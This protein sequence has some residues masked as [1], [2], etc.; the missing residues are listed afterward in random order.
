M[1]R[2]KN[3]F[4]GNRLVAVLTQPVQLFDQLVGAHCQEGL[5][6]HI[7]LYCVIGQRQIVVVRP[8]LVLRGDGAQ[9]GRHVS[10]NVLGAACQQTQ[11]ESQ[12]QHALE[13]VKKVVHG[14][15]QKRTVMSKT[16]RHSRSRLPS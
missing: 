10:G 2:S 13:G 16:K 11:G 6:R 4:D 1:V 5:V 8:G 15:S 3:L 9:F 12:G 7:V 14:S